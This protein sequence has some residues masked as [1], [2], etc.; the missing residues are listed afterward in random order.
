MQ[1]FWNFFLLVDKTWLTVF[2]YISISYP[3]WIIGPSG[4]TGRPHPTAAT[5]EKNLTARVFT[6]NIC[7][8]IVPFRKPVTSGIP[9][10][11]ALG[12]KNC[13][14]YGRKT[15]HVFIDNIYNNFM[16][17]CKNTNICWHSSKVDQV[18]LNI[19]LYIS[20]KI[21]WYVYI[22]WGGEVYQI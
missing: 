8:T 7:R 18:R 1:N 16:E 4:P 3:I 12:R 13:I 22:V 14:N 6:L 2:D 21:Y 19:V 17:G 5:Q 10:P 20:K 11:P 9:D 15:C